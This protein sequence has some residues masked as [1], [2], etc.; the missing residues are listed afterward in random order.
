M[1]QEYIFNFEFNGLYMSCG[2][3][4]TQLLVY[5]YRFK[6]HILKQTCRFQNVGQDSS[7]Y[8]RL[9]CRSSTIVGPKFVIHSW[10]YNQNGL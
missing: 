1:D 3:A 6:V 8:H 5:Y 7:K 9:N 4:S 10:T 2:F